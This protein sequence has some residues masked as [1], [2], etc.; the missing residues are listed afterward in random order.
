MN[1][2]ANAA[3]DEEVEDLGRLL[4]ARPGSAVVVLDQAEFFNP[5]LVT[6]ARLE[7]EL[8]LT[9]AERGPGWRLLVPGATLAS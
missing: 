8:G 6:G 7:D 5:F 4:R 1:R 2:R 9:V 3:V